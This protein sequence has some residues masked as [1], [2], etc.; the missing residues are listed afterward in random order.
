MIEGILGLLVVIAGVVAEAMR[1]KWKHEEE[2]ADRNARKIAELLERRN[3]AWNAGDVGG[4][5]DSTIQ[6]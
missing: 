6:E 1:R 4:V 2:R 3:D 5:F